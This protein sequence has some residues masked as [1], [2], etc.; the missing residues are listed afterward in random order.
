M[1]WLKA[2]YAERSTKVALLGCLGFLGG[3]VS[4]TVDPTTALF[5]IA[6]TIAHMVVPDNAMVG[7]AGAFAPAAPVIDPNK[8]KA[9]AATFVLLGLLLSTGACTTAQLQSAQSSVNAIEVSAVKDANTFCSI[10]GKVAPYIATG[11]ALASVIYP[12]AGVTLVAISGTADP[13]LA[14]A[15]AAVG[16]ITV[17]PAK[18]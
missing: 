14:A 2:R 15:C 11:A 7:I 17:S 12:P 13:I 18:S 16:G 10:A 4:G 5:G 1:E 6:Y 3:L 9:L 8:L